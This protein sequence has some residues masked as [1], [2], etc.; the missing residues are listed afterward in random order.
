MYAETQ[1]Q[2]IV[3]CLLT[4]TYQ[5]P[6]QR[7]SQHQKAGCHS[8]LGSNC[9]P[10]QTAFNPQDFEDGPTLS[11]VASSAQLKN[12]G[13]CRAEKRAS[14]AAKKQVV[15][16]DQG[17]AAIYGQAAPADRQSTGARSSDCQKQQ[18]NVFAAADND[19]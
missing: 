8:K 9:A 10:Q 13:S 1:N 16:C 14:P 7:A 18:A 2:S 6:S 12:Q 5:Q 4:S 11:E 17:F 19:Y 3:R 15:V